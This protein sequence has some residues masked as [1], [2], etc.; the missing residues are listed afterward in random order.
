MYLYMPRF[1]QCYYYYSLSNTQITHRLIKFVLCLGFFVLSFQ[2]AF[3]NIY[4]T[5]TTTEL[6]ENALLHLI[7]VPEISKI[8]WSK[9]RII[10]RV[11]HSNE[12]RFNH[13]RNTWLRTTFGI[14]LFF[15][16]S[17]DHLDPLTSRV[18]LLDCQWSAN[19]IR[20]T[21]TMI[22]RLPKKW[23]Q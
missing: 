21:Q 19:N 20:R 18:D 4:A 6:T 15:F 22:C 10:S 9:V 13:T 1:T 16:F 7:L 5:K 8:E 14:V 3:M 2:H 17:I 11:F 23:P 12:N